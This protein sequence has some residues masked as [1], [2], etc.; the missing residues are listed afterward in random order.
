MTALTR[1]PAQVVRRVGGG[2]ALVAAAFVQAPGRLSPDTKL[3]L[4]VDPVAFLAR[5]WT[6]WEPQGAF[7]QLQNQAYGYFLPMGPFFALGHLSGIP[8]WVTQRAWW[9]LLLLVA[10]TGF[11]ALADRL[12]IGTPGTR[13]LAAL[14]F[15][16][17]PRAVTELGGISAELWPTAVAP[18][19]LVPLV[20]AREGGERRAAARSAVAVACAGGV[21]AV[22]VGAALP[23]A[24][25]WLV[26]GTVG[27]VRRRVATWWAVL[28]PAAIAW[29]LVPL[30]LLGRYSPPFL[31]WI[32]SSST[33][34]SV[35]SLPQALRGTTHWVAW[36]RGSLTVWPAGGE[37]VSSGL[38]VALGWAAVL[39][40]LAALLMRSTPHRA[41]LVGG[42]VV[43]VALLTVGHVGAATP[44]WAGA[45]R[46]L[47]DGPGAP[48][49]NTHKFDVVVRL[50]LMLALAHA[51][52]AIRLPVLASAPWAR[53]GVR[54][55]AVC[56]VAGTAVPA[57]AAGL[58]AR[59]T[60]TEVPPYWSQAARWLATNDDGGRTLVVPGAPFA[61][62]LWGDPRDE[63][64][65]ALARTPW[66][67]RNVVP[68]SSAGNIRML[69][70]VEQQL[71]TGRGSPGLAAYLARAGVT[72]L[73]VRADLAGVPGSTPRA[74]TVRSALSG[75]PGLVAR[76][77]FGPPVGG[78]RVG[79]AVVD[80]GLDVTVPALEVW[81]VEAP[82]ARAQVWDA[83]SVVRVA[84]GPENLLALDDA[85]LLD[86]RPV[87]LDG[88]PEA[89]G[90]RVATGDGGA[91]L[92]VTDGPQRREATFSAVRDVWSAPLTATAPWSARRAAHDW[93]V[94]DGPQVV[95]RYAGVADVTASSSAGAAASP[96][97]LLD[98]DPLTQWRTAVLA[99]GTPWWQVRFT[100][101]RLAPATVTVTPAARSGVTA[102]DVV[103]ETG[104]RRTSMSPDGGPAR[105]VEV[106][107]GPTRWLRIELTGRRPA[108]V[109][110]QPGLGAVTIPG[111]APARPLRLPA[112][113]D[114]PTDVVL[115]TARDGADGCVLLGDRPLCG[116]TLARPGEEDLRLDRVIPLPAGGY[117]VGAQVRPRPSQAWDAQL[118][119]LGDPL[120]ATA[121]SRRSEEAAERPQA[122]VD[123]DLGSGW[124]ASALDPA[125]ALTLEWS[126]RRAVSAFQL[127]T[128]AALAVSRAARVTVTVGGRARSAAVG[129]DGWV[130]FPAMTGTS[131]TLTVT[132]R[133]VQRG[134]DP[135]R[136]V[137]ELPFGV[138]EVVVPALDDLRRPLD[139]DARTGVACGFGPDLVV[140]DVTVPTRVEGTVRDLL[141][142][143]AMAAV[144]CGRGRSAGTGRDAAARVSVPGGDLRVT[145]AATPL[146]RPE[147]V[148]LRGAEGLPAAT[149]RPVTVRRWDAEHRT[150]AVP[151][152][153]TARLLVVHEN[154]NPGWRATVAG[155]P[156]TN[157]RVDGWQQGWVLPAGP[158][159]T[160][161]LTFAPGTGYRLALV[162]GGV[163]LL[164]VAA[165][166][167]PRRR[168][169][170][171]TGDVPVPDAAP[172]PVRAGMSRPALVTAAAA[173]VV[174]GGW[175]AAAALCLAGL[176]ARRS[177]RATVV[178]ATAGALVA[179]A[180]SVARAGTVPGDSFADGL[181]A[182]ALWC[183]LGCAVVL[184]ASGS[185][186]DVAQPALERPLD[187]VPGQ[188]GQGEGRDGRGGEQGQEGDVERP[189]VE[190]LDDRDE[191]DHVPQEEP[192]ADGAG[193]HQR[194]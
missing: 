20:A 46:D 130:R 158:A 39:L 97:A 17:S 33:T 112:V 1:D 82:T 159:G 38:L 56:A 31:D 90:L 135:D 140:G 142:R 187:E 101:S 92:V 36:L 98:D 138:S 79:D 178:L 102:V 147:S 145:V 89:A 28:V 121:S 131:L 125:P 95:A 12:R 73:L 76:A 114:P 115:R 149:P 19:V 3:D 8:A 88:D 139:L 146:W 129:T 99:R 32:E 160:V 106:P 69:T 63:P 148:R 93:T 117:R 15:A 29:W 5:A 67:V 50:P 123:R 171:A 68:L 43:G 120:V 4:L 53:H 24:V 27:R 134:V 155:R 45:V 157:V 83:G 124:V 16:L 57:L 166:A 108:L 137:V 183:A 84:G 40:G 25:V 100:A 133:R 127:Q 47:L 176:V 71:S 55:V 173:L 172:A 118:R 184:A 61:T 190:P 78:A 64:L 52:A 41:F 66:A 122:A 14:A 188:G 103:T 65:Q 180:V 21:N 113:T 181:C 26:T 30:V 58:P 179:A 189:Q 150:L 70:T 104:R 164:G 186:D 7:G 177:R 37:L 59:G 174:A 168:R 49:R 144:P 162:L 153:A 23:L 132:E 107:P 161:E 34:T 94:F 156:L 110:E 6:L 167:A 191:H 81:Q 193:P 2:A 18:W 42:V 126:G 72:R 22:A 62:S 105:E 154:A 151:A 86:G 85:G 163:L 80:D 74:V 77:R 44:P 9:A 185:A 128:D 116:S 75:S 165:L 54:F 91:P 35:A 170:A 136:G 10:Y 48:L 169:R 152:A 175:W 60:F 109:P 13:I 111:A 192:V 143:R 11:L 194:S 96:W 51:V 182:V 119:P 141:E 87:V